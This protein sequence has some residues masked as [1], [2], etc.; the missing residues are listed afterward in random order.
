MAETL[1]CVAV[2]RVIAMAKC[3]YK[4]ICDEYNRRFDKRLYK[5]CNG[6]CRFFKSASD[7]A[8]NTAES[9]NDSVYD[10]VLSGYES[11]KNKYKCVYFKE[12]YENGRI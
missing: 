2:Y 4:D 12:E 3:M 8:I 10:A 9:I 5:S 1:F 6:K 11:N 7:Y